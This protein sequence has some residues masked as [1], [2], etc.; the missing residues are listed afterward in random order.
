M[1]GH[2]SGVDDILIAGDEDLE[3]L[4]QAPGLRCLRSGV[5]KEYLGADADLPEPLE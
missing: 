4:E 5:S 3:P 1:V 2:V